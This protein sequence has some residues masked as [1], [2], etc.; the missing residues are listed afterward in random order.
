MK[1]TLEEIVSLTGGTLISSET[2]QTN[3]EFQGMASLNDAGALDVSFLGNEKY[4][5]DFLETKAGV[6]LIPPSIPDF[7]G[8]VYL[9]EVE[10]PTH[11]FGQIVKFFA[12]AQLSFV[13]GVHPTAYV[14]DNVIFDSEKVCIKAGAI[15]ESGVVIGDG[16][17]IGAGAVISHDVVI[18]ENCIL[19]A[20][21]TVRERCVIGQRVILQPGCV[22]GSDGYGFALVNGR[23][24][25]I[26][27]VGIVVLEDDVEI[28]ANSTVD[29]ARFGKTIIGEGSKIDNQVQIGHNVR[30]GKHCL[31]VSQV[32][33][34]G[35]TEVGDYVTMAG[36][37]GTAG[38]LKIG[39]KAT[40]T[41]RT[42]AIKDLKGGVVYMGMPAR[43]M[44]E[45]L[46]KQ[47]NLA[48]LP[49]FLAEVKELRR[50]LDEQG[51]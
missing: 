5:Q 10:N 46:K 45:E 4:Y 6:V 50:I 35:S 21:C 36:Q 15:V 28:G 9:V 44:R 39:D 16:T 7:L 25:K 17:E 47:A 34:S 27:Q 49:K 19:H 48:R 37:A 12:E 31:I 26:D 33:I 51:E 30:M 13:A 2:S 1:L 40:L 14:A 24:E 38:H 22:I 3:H 29:R 8:D 42:G 23:H 41:G 11:A 18:G 43:P 32:G 20:N